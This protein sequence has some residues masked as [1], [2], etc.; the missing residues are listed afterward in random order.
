MKNIIFLS[1]FVVFFA[2]KKNETSISTTPQY[3]IIDKVEVYEFDTLKSLV[4]KIAWDN[5][6]KG[7]NRLPDIFIS[8]KNRSDDAVIWQSST[9]NNNAP[10][11]THIYTPQTSLKIPFQNAKI[12]W[13]VND[14]D[15]TTSEN[16]MNTFFDAFSDKPTFSACRFNPITGANLYAKI[17]FRYE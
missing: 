6:E 1:V 3:I 13:F 14:N 9:I 2:C 15:G 7:L 10:N 5:D 4:N 16:I 17:F 12:E 11:Q 8:V